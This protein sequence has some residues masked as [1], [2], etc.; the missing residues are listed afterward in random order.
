MEGSACCPGARRGWGVCGCGWE[1]TWGALGMLLLLGVPPASSPRASLPLPTLCE[2]LLTSGITLHVLSL[3]KLQC[4]IKENKWNISGRACGFSGRRD[5]GSRL[6]GRREGWQG[7]CAC[8]LCSGLGMPLVLPA[9]HWWS[10]PPSGGGSGS[11]VLLRSAAEPHSQL[12]PQGGCSRL[13]SPQ[14]SM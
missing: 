6:G 1:R 9:L 14:S 3:L 13:C 11:C 7:C 12:K 2:L 5:Q 4:N 10:L 8:A